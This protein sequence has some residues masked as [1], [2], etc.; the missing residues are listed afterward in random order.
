M[1][2]HFQSDEFEYAMGSKAL[3]RYEWSYLDKGATKLLHSLHEW[4]NLHSQKLFQNVCVSQKQL[5]YYQRHL[6]WAKYRLLQHSH[7]KWLNK[8]ISHILTRHVH[9]HGCV[10]R[11]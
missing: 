3:K 11:L 4:H 1:A 9:A 6:V 5:R 2:D 8:Q 10:G 7:Q